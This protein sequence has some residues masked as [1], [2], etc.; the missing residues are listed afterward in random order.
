MHFFGE[1]YAPDQCIN[2]LV[3]IIL[4]YGG[5]IEVQLKDH[6]VCF[7]HSL[8]ACLKDVAFFEIHRPRTFDYFEV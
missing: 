8:E 4:C 7:K 3:M 5:S 6:V 2:P 1:S